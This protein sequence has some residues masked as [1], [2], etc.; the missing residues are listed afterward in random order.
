M[1]RRRLAR[2]V[3]LIGS[4]MAVVFLCKFARAQNLQ[5]DWISDMK[6]G[7]KIW[8]NEPAPNES[9]TWS[10]GCKGGFGTGFGV[11]VWF[12]NGKFEERDVGVLLHGQQN[13]QDAQTF[14][15]GDK[16]IQD[17]KNGVRTGEDTYIFPNGNVIVGVFDDGHF[18]GKVKETYP[19]GETYIG[20]FSDD[21]PNGHGI[22][23]LAN[24]DK[25]V[26]EFTDGL[27]NGQGTYTTVHGYKYVGEFKNGAFSGQGTETYPN[28]DKWVG[29]FKNGEFN[30]QGTYTRVNGDKYVGDFIDGQLNGQGTY[31]TTTVPGYKYVGEFQDGN[32][33]GQ[34][35]ETWSS[36]EK[37]S[38]E[39]RDNQYDGP[40][41]E[42]FADGTQYVGEWLD[43][44][45]NGQGTLYSSDGT[46]LHSGTWKDDVFVQDEIP[47]VSENGVLKIPV[48]INGAITLNFIIDS[49]SADVSIPADVVLVLLR[50]GTLNSGDFLGTANYILADGST[51]PSQEFHIRSL[52]VGDRVF[53]NIV[54]SVENANAPL[55]LGQSFLSRFKSWSINNSKH[56]LELQN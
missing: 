31:T 35:T 50:T 46:V 14:S 8:D 51:V 53:D 44:K 10:G 52:K 6:T 36:G 20:S 27:F 2:G 56:T 3:A 11:Q 47:L 12:E 34:G 48:N 37:H 28:G 55:L 42:I 45:R 32:F 38:G 25:Y 21:N 43:N 16:S 41:T 19:N 23:T 39:F 18:I 7:C 54:G 17:W 40:G 15:N 13:G 49:G 30:G 1:I 5:P 4:G 24:G 29:A 9:V 33:N 26:G 22:A